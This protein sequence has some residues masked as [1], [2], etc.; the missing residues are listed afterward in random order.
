MQTRALSSRPCGGGDQR[1]ARTP[2]S[3]AV[4]GHGCL[5]PSAIP[6]RVGGRTWCPGPGGTPA[7]TRKPRCVF[8][9]RLRIGLSLASGSQPMVTGAASAGGLPGGIWTT[10][11]MDAGGAGHL[12]SSQFLLSAK[13][14]QSR[15]Q[16]GIW[17]LPG[18]PHLTAGR[19]PA[20]TT[21]PTKGLGDRKQVDTPVFSREASQFSNGLWLGPVLLI[22]LK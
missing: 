5:C 4:L 20:N 15:E 9:K 7:A 16:V 18:N 22:C 10:S 8:R 11:H 17:R 12:L 14:V 1:G 13:R 6:M 21:T 3:D 2:M 19:S